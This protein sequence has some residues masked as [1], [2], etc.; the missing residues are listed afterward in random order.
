MKLYIKNM[1]CERCKTIVKRELDNVGVK[2]NSVQYGEV[3]TTED[4]TIS[5]RTKLHDALQKSGFELIDS[6]KHALIE[7]LKSAIHDMEGF[8]DED[9][10]TSFTDYISLR[11]NDNFISLNTLFSE[12]EGVTIEKY[13]IRRKI[14]RVKEMLVYEDI[15][16]S[17]IAHKLHYSNTIE[18]VRQFKSIT[19]LTPSHFSLLRCSRVQNPIVIE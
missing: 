16:L 11:V 18:L 17:E 10:K 12:L 3:D 14:E 5:Q 19:G 13:I 9:L 15:S 4:L 8:S 2:Y 1:V 7:D 6:H